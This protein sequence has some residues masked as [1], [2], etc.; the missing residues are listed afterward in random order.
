M[1]VRMYDRLR[2]DGLTIWVILATTFR[3]GLYLFTVFKET[4]QLES[5]M[6]NKDISANGITHTFVYI[7][8]HM[9]IVGYV[10]IHICVY[11][12]YIHFWF[13]QV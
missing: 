6:A 7:H 11:D 8:L 9:Y 3:V 4:L 5:D 12:I 1:A 2:C 13:S 10:C